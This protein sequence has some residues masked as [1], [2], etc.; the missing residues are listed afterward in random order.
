MVNSGISHNHFIGYWKRHRNLA[1]RYSLALVFWHNQLDSFVTLTLLTLQNA[2]EAISNHLH[3]LNKLD[4]LVACFLNPHTGEFRMSS[5]VSA[6][7]SADSYYEYLVKQWIQTGRSRD[8]WVGMLTTTAAARMG[9]VTVTAELAFILFFSH[10][11]A[12]ETTRLC[13]VCT[14][15]TCILHVHCRLKQ[16]YLEAVDGIKKH[17]LRYSVPSKYAFVGSYNSM[18][19]R[20]FR[21]EMVRAHQ[22]ALQSAFVCWKRSLVW[23]VTGMS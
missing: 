20:H 19:A 22:H 21:N 3:T 23:D 2:V 1:C 16:D 9:G 5:A 17:L 7:A 6:G 8:W 12:S 4:G 10:Q 11:P 13:C 18:T 14:I 15:R